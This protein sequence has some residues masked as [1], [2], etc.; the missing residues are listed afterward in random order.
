VAQ[1][2]QEEE[3][4]PWV[5]APDAQGDMAEEEGVAAAEPEVFPSDCCMWD[6]RPASTARRCRRRFLIPR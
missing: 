3:E 4:A 6:A 2:K 1:E 5:P